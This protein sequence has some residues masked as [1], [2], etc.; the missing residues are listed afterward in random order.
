M[1]LINGMDGG[2]ATSLQNGKKDGSLMVKHLILLDIDGTL[3]WT[4][5]AG[6][7]AMKAAMQ[8]VYGTHGTL[9]TYN[10]GGRTMLEIM[11]VAL[12]EG[13]VDKEDV[14]AKFDI[15]NTIMTGKLREFAKN[16]KYNFR[17]CPGGLDLVDALGKRPDVMVGLVTGNP[18]TTATIKLE[19]AGYDATVFEVGG[20]GHESIVRADL[21]ESAIERS[22]DI[23]GYRIDP[24]CTVVLGDTIKDV[25]AAK[26]HGTRAVVVA[27]GDDALDVLMQ[28][29]ADYGLEDL[30]DTEEV[31]RALIG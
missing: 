12:S 23:L 7:A 21:I 9:D 4:G 16:G 27:T 10:P 11:E 19:A 5:G 31:L 3:V 24:Q 6:R 15:Y 2:R 14:H 18:E 28:S 26:V 17:A 29:E 30:T 8:E 20:Y 25:V 22:V 13:G 1:R